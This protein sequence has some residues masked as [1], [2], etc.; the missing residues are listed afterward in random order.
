MPG[1]IYHLGTGNVKN[2]KS[3]DFV[4]E[5]YIGIIF[6]YCPCC[7]KKTEIKIISNVDDEHFAANINCMCKN[8]FEIEYDIPTA[9]VKISTCVYLK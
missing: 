4:L 8:P 7:G 5:K 2:M 3:G 1:D 6:I 9:E